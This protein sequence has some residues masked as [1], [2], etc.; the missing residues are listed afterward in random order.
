MIE[1]MSW[2]LEKTTSDTIGKKEKCSTNYTECSHNKPVLWPASSLSSHR[3]S[4]ELPAR[5]SSQG[6]Q[7]N[8]EL[9]LRRTR[10][11][12]VPKSQNFRLH[13]KK[14]LLQIT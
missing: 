8:L 1:K 7:M 5:E 14:W 12:E 3:S 4:P 13:M 11:T 2:S 9:H 10:Q 6:P